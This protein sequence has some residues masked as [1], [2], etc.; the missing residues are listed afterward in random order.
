MAS[1]FTKLKFQE[2]FHAD[3]DEH[4]GISTVTFHNK[5]GKFVGTARLNPEDEGSGFKGC[6]IAESRANIQ[7]YKTAIRYQKE[8]IKML[9]SVLKNFGFHSRLAGMLENELNN[10]ELINKA[11]RAEEKYLATY[12][13]G[14]DKSRDFRELM[15]AQFAVG[16]ND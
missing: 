15:L 14:L 8:R 11:L 6:H 12:I 4:T 9:N 3:Y 2:N 7:Y 1:I 13:A 10:L 16:K 5:Y